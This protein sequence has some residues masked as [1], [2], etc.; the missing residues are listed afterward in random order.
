MKSFLSSRVCFPETQ[1]R[2][3][4]GSAMNRAGRHILLATR[5]ALA[6]DGDAGAIFLL[7]LRE[8]NRLAL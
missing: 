3:R 4:F 5:L 6:S 7:D 2:G 1:A 8:F